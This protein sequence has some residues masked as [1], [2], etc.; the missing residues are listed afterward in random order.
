MDGGTC[1]TTIG[2][3]GGS[4]GGEGGVDGGPCSVSA[5]SSQCGVCATT[6]CCSALEQCAGSMD[7]KNLLS[8]EDDCR[9]GA[10]CVT[11]CEQKYPAAVSTLQ[12][13][14]G[15][16][17][18]DCPVCNESGV[19]DPCGPQFPACEVGLTCTGLWCTRP[20]V[21]AADCVGLGP[22]GASDLG[23][24]NECMATTSGEVCTPGC[25]S[26]SDCAYF[27]GTYCLSTTS[28]DGTAVSVCAPLPDASTD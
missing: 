14:S 12:L 11:A 16:L 26:A 21:R 4:S 19:G 25:A 8:C 17:A 1:S 24:A 7:C 27:P 28:A 9:G 18:R 5:G 15:C 10:T 22:G 6:S 23:F 3:G 2:G 20:C 13:V